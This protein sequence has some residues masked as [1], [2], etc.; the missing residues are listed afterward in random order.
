MKI[1]LINFF[2]QYNSSK[3]ELCGRYIDDCI[4]AIS[5]TKEKLNQ[6]ITAVNSFHPL[7]KYTCEISNSSLAF[8]EIKVLSKATAYSHMCATNPRILIVICCT[9]LHIHHMS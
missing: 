4:G 5:S 6:F 3:P 9:H 8:L 7:P 2:N 1:V